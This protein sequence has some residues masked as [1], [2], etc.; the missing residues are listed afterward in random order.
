MKT[1][2]IL[3]DRGWAERLMVGHDYAPPEVL[4]GSTTV[5]PRPTRLLHLST[6]ALPALRASGVSDEVIRT[7]THDVPRR[8]LTGASA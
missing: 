1:L 3:I 6:V 7:M 4:R 5:A 2:K 8:F